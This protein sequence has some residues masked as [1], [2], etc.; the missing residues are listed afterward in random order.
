[1]CVSLIAAEYYTFARQDSQDLRKKIYKIQSRLRLALRRVHN[2]LHIKKYCI[3]YVNE[4][5]N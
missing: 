5:V 2:T 1:M 3:P 4:Y